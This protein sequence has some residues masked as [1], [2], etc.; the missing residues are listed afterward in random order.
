MKTNIPQ[1]NIESKYLYI[2]IALAIILALV[3]AIKFIDFKEDQNP[4]Y[5]PSEANG[6][7]LFQG[8]MT[9]VAR[10]GELNIVQFEKDN[11]ASGEFTS[12]NVGFYVRIDLSL[13]DSA[14][15]R[16]NQSKNEFFPEKH[17][18]GNHTVTLAS[19]KPVNKLHANIEIYQITSI[20]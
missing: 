9:N 8:E 16:L 15:I 1:E 4:S 17:Y 10:T 20:Y 11:H 5:P 6:P 18:Q 12:N 7:F 13:L 19:Q 3:F 2:L 14:G